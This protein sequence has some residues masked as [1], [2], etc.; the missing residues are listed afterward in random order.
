MF[1]NENIVVSV[2]K[3]SE[4]QIYYKFNTKETNGVSVIGESPCINSSNKSIQIII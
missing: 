1:L 3:N 4:K 2:F